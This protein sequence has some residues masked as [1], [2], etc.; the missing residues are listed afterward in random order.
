MLQNI[1]F[2]GKMEPLLTYNARTRGSYEAQT[3]HNTNC[4]RAHGSLEGSC[5]AQTLA[6]NPLQRLG[7]RAWH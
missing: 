3:I 7:P 4:R 1:E 2:L 5:L 6:A